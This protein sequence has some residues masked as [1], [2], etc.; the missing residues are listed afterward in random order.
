M[1]YSTKK[2]ADITVTDGK[3]KVVIKGGVLQSAALAVRAINHPLRKKIVD[4][5]NDKGEMVVTDIYVQLKT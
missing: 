3:E 4:L 2:I 1:G 5:L